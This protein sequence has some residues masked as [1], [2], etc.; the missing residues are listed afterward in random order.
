M[1]A[2]NFKTRGMC[3]PKGKARVYF[4][5]HPEDFTLYFE[6]V[7]NDILRMQNC[8]VW[9]SDTTADRDGEFLQQLHEMQLFVMPVTHKLL[10]TSNHALDIEF[11]FATENHIPV[12]PLMFEQGL[13]E[14]FNQKC[15]DIQFLDKYSSDETAISYT[16]KLEKYLSSV[17]IGDDLAEKVRAAFDAYVF[18]SYRKKDRKYAQELMRLIHKHEFCRDIAIWYD[19]YLTPGENFNDSIKAALE[20][21]GLFV[22]TVTPNLVN[23]ENYIMTTEYP[24]AKQQNK[25]ILPAEL[26]P[27]DRN[28]L[29]EKYFEI[30]Q[31]ANARNEVELSKALLSAVQKMAIKENDQSPVHNFFIGLAYLNGIDVEV[32]RE[33]AVKLITSAAE[34]G[35][36]EAIDQLVMMLRMGKGVERSYKKAIEWQ[37]KKIEC[38][39]AAYSQ[40]P[41]FENLKI[42]VISM[43]L[44]GDYYVELAQIENAQK[45]YDDAS[46]FYEAC[47]LEKTDD[48]K[49]LLFTLEQRLGAICTQK[50]DRAGTKSHYARC[51]DIASTLG[52]ELADRRN[53]VAAFNNIGVYYKGEGETSEARKHYESALDIAYKIA[54]ETQ[55]LPDLRMYRICLFNIG[56]I[57]LDE[58]NPQKAEQEFQRALQVANMLINID[59][60]AVARRDKAITLTLLGSAVKRQGRLSDASRHYTEA[61]EI[62]E[63]VAEETE[64]VTAKY[65]LCICYN[66]TGTVLQLMGEYETAKT[67]YETSLKIAE[68][69]NAEC[70]TVGFMRVTAINLVNLGYIAKMQGNPD[71]AQEYYKRSIDVRTELAGMTGSVSDRESLAFANNRLGAIYLEKGALDM[72]EECFKNALKIYGYLLRRT[73]KSNIRQGEITCWLNI[74]DVSNKQGNLPEARESF[75]K[76]LLLAEE[77]SKSCNT[78]VDRTSEATC[79]GRLG[80][81]CFKENDL[82]KAKEFFQK[83]LELRILIHNESETAEALKNLALAHLSMANVLNKLGNKQMAKYHYCSEAK[84]LEKLIETVKTKQHS[85]SLAT[86]LKNAAD[87]C[88]EEK[89]YDKAEELYSKQLS[90][91]QSLLTEFGTETFASLTICCQCYLGRALL[92]LGKRDEAVHQFEEYFSLSEGWFKK[93]ASNIFLSNMG[94]ACYNLSVAS[95]DRQKEMLQKA[96]LYTGILS[97]KTPEIDRYRKRLEQYKQQYA[98][99]FGQQ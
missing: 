68:H 69:F 80:N 7:C 61:L 25:P 19:E 52:D 34:A 5:C 43:I 78:A 86:A 96:I 4:C 92:N 95:P 11:R 32:D 16:E 81:V 26:V 76:A 83:Q 22:L 23:E 29:A 87:I 88:F 48:V 38:A 65:D 74:G 41:N 44:C 70:N 10:N 53:T 66:D 57:C 64:T 49:R 50:G 63:K 14:I 9:Y 20:K 33:R 82:E 37:K 28:L 73:S 3:D 12:L 91:S 36:M 90:V 93:T 8:A 30:P 42:A 6:S 47:D 94:I 46:G 1:T 89:D 58:G 40:E 27:T 24:M 79:Y 31:C 54:T 97:S 13:V 84:H 55:E 85:H 2:L 15:G 60:S 21:S 77:Y 35:L 67:Y 99:K 51:V 56:G 71:S 75:E 62:Y 59:D 45:Q 72:A 39:I 17:L 18:L 98:K